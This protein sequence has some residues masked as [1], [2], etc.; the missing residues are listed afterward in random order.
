MSPH[1]YNFLFLNSSKNLL[2]LKLDLNSVICYVSKNICLQKSR[3]GGGFRYLA[4]GLTM[5]LAA[6]SQPF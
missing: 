3:G 6:F 2:N 1:I 5:L 4:H